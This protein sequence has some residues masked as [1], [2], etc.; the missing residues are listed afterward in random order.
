MVIIENSEN[1]GNQEIKITYNPIIHREVT[2][3][4]WCMSFQLF[5]FHLYYICMV[6]V[7]MY[8]YVK[9]LCG[10]PWVAQWLSA[11]LQPRA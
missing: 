7:Y 2:V 6:H 8:R 5:T 9:N 1:K 4:F 3:T 11:C 10:D